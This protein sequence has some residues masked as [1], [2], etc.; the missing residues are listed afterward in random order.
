LLYRHAQ[1]NLEKLDED[2]DFNGGFAENIVRAFRLRMQYIRA[3]ANENDLRL[4]KSFRFEKLK[5]DRKDQYSLRLNQQFRLILEFEQS[6]HGKVAVI[7]A[8]E[9]YH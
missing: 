3:A 2:P 4:M 5:G 9:D 1:K 8:I 6:E 7:V